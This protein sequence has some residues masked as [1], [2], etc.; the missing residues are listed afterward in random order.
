MP[1]DLIYQ[2]ID[3][4]RGSIIM[5]VYG[6]EGKKYHLDLPPPLLLHEI[7]LSLSFLHTLQI[8]EIQHTPTV[9]DYQECLE[10]VRN[11]GSQLQA[12]NRCNNSQ[13]CVL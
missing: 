2:E 9:R 13:L 7:Y 6:G 1:V 12:I 11:L 5:Y 3:E 8:G 4:V 10:E